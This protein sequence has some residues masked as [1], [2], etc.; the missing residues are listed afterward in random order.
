[1][2]NLFFSYDKNNVHDQGELICKELQYAFSLQELLQRTPKGG[3]P[4]VSISERKQ[5]QV[6]K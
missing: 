5:A 1:M 3:Q 2:P 6:V 4:R